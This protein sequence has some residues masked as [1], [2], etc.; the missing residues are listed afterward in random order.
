MTTAEIPSAA[1]CSRRCRRRAGRRSPSLDDD[2]IE[3]TRTVT[4]HLNAAL[5][6]R[7][8]TA[9]HEPGSSDRS[10][11]LPRRSRALSTSG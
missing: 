7:D 5:Q 3:P 4:T 10:G 6:N 9:D 1:N 11:A 2:E 8:R